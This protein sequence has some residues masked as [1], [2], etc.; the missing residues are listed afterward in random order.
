MHQKTDEVI[1]PLAK[2]SKLPLAVRFHRDGSISVQDTE[3]RWIQRFG[4]LPA[5][6]IN[7]LDRRTRARLWYR[8]FKV[9]R[10]WAE[11]HA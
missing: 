9:E 5:R 3:G 6:I 7:Q 4:T 2:Q 11:A 10:A 8:N 1:T